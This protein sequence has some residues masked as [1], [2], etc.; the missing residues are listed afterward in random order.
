MSVTNT[1]TLG[2]LATYDEAKQ[3]LESAFPL[4][5]PASTRFA[6]SAIAGFF[7]TFTLTKH[8]FCLF[9]SIF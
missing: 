9:R 6:S 7:G 8:H 2:M 1:V 5:S 3:S 4:M